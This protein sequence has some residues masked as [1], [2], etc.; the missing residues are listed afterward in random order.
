M[1]KKLPRF[2][3]QTPQRSERAMGVWLWAFRDF[4][5]KTQAMAFRQPPRPGLL[6]LA[7]CGGQKGQRAS[8]DGT[9]MFSVPIN[10]CS[11]TQPG[12]GERRLLSLLRGYRSY[13]MRSASEP[14]N[15][16]G[17]EHEDHEEC[18]VTEREKQ[19]QQRMF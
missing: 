13:R 12:R 8:W 11:F 16:E 6:G 10:L 4:E 2:A 14:K 15:K 7:L 9:H 18:T 17:T 19:A 1:L 3:S 5:G